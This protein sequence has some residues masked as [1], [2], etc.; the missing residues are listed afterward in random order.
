MAAFTFKTITP[1]ETTAARAAALAEAA[2]AFPFLGAVSAEGLLA[3]VAAELG[4]AEA[5]DR[6][7]PY[8]THR[9]REA[10]IRKLVGFNLVLGLVTVAVAMLGRIVH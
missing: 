10:Q 4:H 2:S 7:V 3:H 5:L 8:A 1:E 6:F 9:A